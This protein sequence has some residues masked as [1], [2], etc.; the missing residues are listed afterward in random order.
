M[1]DIKV[2]GKG[3]IPQTS[4]IDNPAPTISDTTPSV[5]IKFGDL[6][7]S[8]HKI[9]EETGSTVSLGNLLNGSKAERSIDAPTGIKVESKAE[10]EY[11]AA[12]DELQ[13]STSAA[14]A[15]IFSIVG[16]TVKSLI[17]INSKKS[18]TSDEITQDDEEGSM[19]EMGT[20]TGG[21]DDAPNEG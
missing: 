20:D 21:A 6:T 18:N 9:K 17:G 3:Q 11:I 12:L 5:F 8:T 1:A 14:G 10:A 19:G 15:N 7:I 13:N 16:D 2:D 4:N